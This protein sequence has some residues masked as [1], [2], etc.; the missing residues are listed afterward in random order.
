MGQT[1][2]DFP[3]AISV[4]RK[5]RPLPVRANQQPAWLSKSLICPA[6][7]TQNE[8]IGHGNRRQDANDS[9]NHY[10]PKRFPLSVTPSR[11]ARMATTTIV[12]NVSPSGLHPVVVPGWPQPLL[13]KTFPRRGKIRIA[14][15]FTRGREPPLFPPA[16]KGSNTQTRMVQPLA[17]LGAYFNLY[18]G[19]H[20][21][22]GAASFPPR[23]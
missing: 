23:P 6:I 20:P 7:S 22:K 10:C 15:G 16:L 2:R 21:R 17:G 13:S 5:N 12:Q 9:R 1:S 11:C 3:P 18:R 14:V 19:F 4:A 8:G